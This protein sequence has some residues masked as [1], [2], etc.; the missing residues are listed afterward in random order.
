[1]TEAITHA[2][3]PVS[4]IPGIALSSGFAFAG[5]L[6]VY[7]WSLRFLPQELESVYGADVIAKLDEAVEK[8]EKVAQKT[9]ETSHGLD[10]LRKKP[11]F[12]VAQS[13][14][15]QL[16]VRVGTSGMDSATR[17]E[18]HERYLAALNWSDDPM[19]DFGPAS[20]DGFAL[21]GKVQK[22]ERSNLHFFEVTL[23]GPDSA[24]GPLFWFLH[25]SFSP[26]WVEQRLSAGSA[27][28]KGVCGGAFWIGVVVPRPGKEALRL[29]LDLGALEGATDEFRN[30]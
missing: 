22:K 26:H 24:A 15:D 5:F 6:L 17:E 10:E 19:K 25:N 7:L 9:E 4:C 11:M 13:A 29:A 2:T 1:M 23:A 12:A 28:Y 21:T 3:A 16:A 30:T 20:G 27:H 8:V 18:I 14:V